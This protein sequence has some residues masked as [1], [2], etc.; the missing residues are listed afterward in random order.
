M[1]GG[2]GGVTMEGGDLFTRVVQFSINLRPNNTTEQA[3]SLHNMA[4]KREGTRGK[5]EGE[6]KRDPLNIRLIILKE[7]EREREVGSVS[8]MQ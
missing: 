2:G 7:R 8:T 6:S 4:K 1:G 5:F 3:S